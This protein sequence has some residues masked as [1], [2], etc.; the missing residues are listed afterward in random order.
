VKREVGE[1]SARKRR[2]VRFKGN[3]FERQKPT[4][5]LTSVPPE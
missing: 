2:R 4:V 3:A 1:E 5:V